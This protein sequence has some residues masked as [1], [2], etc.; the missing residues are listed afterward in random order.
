MTCFDPPTEDPHARCEA[1]EPDEHVQ[2][3]RRIRELE[4]RLAGIEDLIDR[5]ERDPIIAAALKQRDRE[6]DEVFK[7]ELLPW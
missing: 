3:Q 4:T 1:P 7:G 2:C 6:I 5:M